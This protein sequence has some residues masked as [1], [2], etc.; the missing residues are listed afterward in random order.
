VQFAPSRRAD[1]NLLKAVAGGV[2][3]VPDMA[4]EMAFRMCGVPR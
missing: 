1:S 3:E 2:G 4:D